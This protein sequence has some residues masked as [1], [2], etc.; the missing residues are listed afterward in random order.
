VV[1]GCCIILLS[2]AVEQERGGAQ[3]IIGVVGGVDKDAIR[4]QMRWKCWLGRAFDFLEDPTA[5]QILL[6]L[7]TLV[8]WI[9]VLT[10]NQ[11]D[12]EKFGQQCLVFTF[13]N[14]IDYP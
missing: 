10:Y 11:L 2:K 6:P 7:E 12:Y 9:W 8:G 14:N 1:D 4:P 13:N 3:R 5:K